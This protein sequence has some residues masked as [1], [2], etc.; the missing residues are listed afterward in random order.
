MCYTFPRIGFVIACALS[1]VGSVLSQSPDPK[2][3]EPVYGRHIVPLLARLGCNSGACHGAVQGQNGFRLSLFGVDPAQ[4]RDHLM[5]DAAGRRLDLN[6]PGN[7]L[8]LMKALGQI[9]HEGGVRVRPLSWEYRLLQQ[10]VSQGVPTGE[11][12]KSRVTKLTVTP[13]ASTVKLGDSISLRVEAAFADGTK[14]DVTGFCTFETQDR[15]VA[16]SEDG[17]RIV[18]LQPGHSAVVIRYGSEPVV[19]MVTVPRPGAADFPAAKGNNFIDEHILAQL[20]RLN[21]PP[22]DVCDDA[23]FLRRVSL[24]LTGGLPSAEEVR[25]FLSDKNP[26]RRAKKI[27]ELLAR[28]G[29]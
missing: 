3:A 5:R 27:D 14:E 18:T 12:P 25:A 19:A 16:K 15:D 26:D 4:D 23:T 2:I 13:P 20:K 8:F 24:D 29:Y 17:G 9:P 28:P 6:N 7:S 11:L 22:S 1:T 21:I 10:W